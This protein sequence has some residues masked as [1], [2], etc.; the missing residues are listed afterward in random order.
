M[1]ILDMTKIPCACTKIRDWTNVSQAD[2][3]M[4]SIGWCEPE[5]ALYDMETC[6]WCTAQVPEFTLR[7]LPGGDGSRLCRE[8]REEA[9][10]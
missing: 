1:V 10:S 2:E 8:C 9:L 5:T 6:S 3:E 4:H 7:E